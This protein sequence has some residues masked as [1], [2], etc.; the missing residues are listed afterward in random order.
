MDAGR[1]E[2]SPRAA[3]GGKAVSA[4]WL[5]AR[6]RTGDTMRIY[7]E[8]PRSPEGFSGEHCRGKGFCPG[9]WGRIRG[10]YELTGRGFAERIVLSVCGAGRYR[11]RVRKGP[12]ASRGPD[13]ESPGSR[14]DSHSQ[15]SP[16]GAL[17]SGDGSETG[18]GGSFD[19]H[20]GTHAAADAVRPAPPLMPF[21]SRPVKRRP[22][23]ASGLS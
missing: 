6:K 14:P 13:G 7:G 20:S 22:A 3:G 21:R 4:T 16:C 5:F 9:G 1:D 19:G 18:G 2:D 11:K 10:F 12:V 17:L 15:R 8:V 23:G